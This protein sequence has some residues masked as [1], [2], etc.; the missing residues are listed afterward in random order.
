MLTSG[1]SHLACSSERNLVPDL[2]NLWGRL[3][4]H[5]LE[6]QSRDRAFVFARLYR[7][8]RATEKQVGHD[9]ATHLFDDGIGFCGREGALASRLKCAT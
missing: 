1:V 4:H 5:H 2:L 8:L 6:P 7:R 9:A 3:R